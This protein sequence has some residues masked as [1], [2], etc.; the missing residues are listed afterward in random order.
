MLNAPRT[1]KS[2]EGMLGAVSDGEP[3]LERVERSS[4]QGVTSKPR[5]G[6]EPSN[7]RG[8]VW[9]EESSRQGP[10]ALA[11]KPLHCKIMGV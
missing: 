8:R 2:K 5:D 1:Q 4:I 6:K 7:L 9:W 11:P 3:P 10:P